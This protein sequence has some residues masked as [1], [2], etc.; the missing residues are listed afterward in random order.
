[1]TQYRRIQAS[2]FFAGLLTLGAFD[3]AAQQQGAAP[4]S[5]SSAMDVAYDE[6]SAV[7]RIQEV[8]ISADGR[9]V[10]WLEGSFEE[11][12]GAKTTLEVASLGD[13]AA[14]AR[15]LRLGG[16]SETVRHIAWSPDGRRMAFLSDADT[17]GQLQVYVADAADSISGATRPLTHLAGE[18]GAPRFSPDGRTIAFLF[19]ENARAAAGPRAAKP[20]ET[21][22][23]GERVDVQRLTT[24]DVASGATRTISPPSLHIHEFDWSPDGKRIAAT[25]SPPPG[26]DGWYVAE[27]FAID[28]A[29]GK[30]TS[31]FTPSTQIGCPRWSPDGSSIAFIAGLMSDEGVL[32][33]EVFVVSLAGGEPRNLTPALPASASWLSWRPGSQEI[34]FAEWMEGQSALAT[35]E[36]DTGRIEE[37]WR[38]AERLSAAPEIYGPNLSVASDGRTT[39]AVRQSFDEPP[40]VW[41]G[42]IGAWARVSRA[43]PKAKRLWG[44]AKGLTWKSGDLEVQGWLVAPREVAPGRRYPMVVS[45]HGGPAS[46]VIPAWPS[47]A[48]AVALATDGFYVFLPNPRGSHGRGLAFVSANMKDLGGGDLG[49][50]LAGVEEVVRTQPVDRDRIGITGGS[51]G[52]FMTM[53]A[54]TQTRRFRAAVAVA[55]IANWQSYWGQNGIARWMLPYFGATV[56]EDPAVYARSSPI[57]FIQNVSTPTLV[58]VGEGDIECPPPQSYEFWRALKALD[59]KT[60]LVVYAGEGHGLTKPENQRDELRRSWAWFRENLVAY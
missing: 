48:S 47:T 27:L 14:S 58:L 34:L 15:P 39:A 9:S 10:A 59:V 41:A 57:N 26:D 29:A 6:L 21:G 4:S 12:S 3:L 32:G 45:V 24:V 33:G 56:Y 7:R 11:D 52:G 43:N 44:E 49:D 8:T 23:I 22:V 13:K 55:G 17:P 60:E 2:I 42:T 5:S 30:A 1:M 38:G 46:A 53:W 37:L 51:Y 35:V 54:V 19:T 36:V 16:K 18:L 25:A 50:I 20:T 28:A 40:E 31:I